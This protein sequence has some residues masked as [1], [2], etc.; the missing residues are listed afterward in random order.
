MIGASLKTKPYSRLAFSA[1]ATVLLLQTG[2]EYF[3]ASESESDYMYEEDIIAQQQAYR[4]S[5]PGALMNTAIQSA[6]NGIK[7]LNGQQ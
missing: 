2:C 5:L 7:S 1:L 4:D 3:R 6:G